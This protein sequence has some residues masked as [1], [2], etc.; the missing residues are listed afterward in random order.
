MA[1][2]QTFCGCHMA[3]LT[4]NQK[5]ALEVHA[6]PKV[7]PPESADTGAWCAY[8]EN[9]Y[10]DAAGQ[11]ARIPWADE[12]PNPALVAWLNREAPSLVRP[13][14]SISV[15]GCG[16]GED[17]AEL[18]DRGYDVLGFDVSPTAV[19]W[20]Q[21]RH[22]NHAERFMAADLFALPTG[23]LRRA[24]LVVEVYTI[25]SVH[26]LL[27]A[28]AVAAV[29]SLVRPRGSVLVICRGR[30]ESEPSVSVPPHPLTESE[31]AALF[32]QHGMTPM[33]SLDNFLD[34]ESP[35]TRRL[36]GVFRSA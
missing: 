25:Q 35:P 17:V 11:A 13:G 36:R 33:R 22:P 12:V 9:L 18:A 19:K 26:P 34:D 8:F 2:I 27:R 24:D 29:T 3:A 20:A 15:V 28:R 1:G 5:Q 21:K 7:L 32:A 23:L 4:H 30:Q 14:A 16:L 31:L 6:E 10:R